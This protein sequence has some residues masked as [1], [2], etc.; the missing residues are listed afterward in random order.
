MAG[1]GMIALAF[2]RARGVQ[3][4]S[5]LRLLAL[6]VLLTSCAF[7]SSESGLIS[8]FRL[9]RNIWY[10]SGISDYTLVYEH[11]CWG[12]PPCMKD[13]RSYVTDG[14]PIALEYADSNVPIYSNNSEGI[15]V[16]PDISH[17]VG[18]LSDELS[19]ATV[20]GLFSLVLS[21]IQE[22]GSWRRNDMWVNYNAELGY[23]ERFMIYS[24]DPEVMDGFY[25]I[26]IL[27]L[28]PG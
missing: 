16:H 4:A 10:K 5:S 9:H 6:A 7:I 2:S 17:I 23:P 22:K 26:F 20:D 1:K 3:I 14:L 28:S 21:L 8:D 18:D 13:F 15:Y 25:G 11:V 19:I 24:T 12:V 27:S